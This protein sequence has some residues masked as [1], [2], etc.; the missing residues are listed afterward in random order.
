MI[1]I[2]WEIGMVSG[3]GKWYNEDQ[4]VMLQGFAEEA[5][6][7]YGAGTHWIGTK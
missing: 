6:G 3:H 4:R 2:E 5:N 7:R 1:R